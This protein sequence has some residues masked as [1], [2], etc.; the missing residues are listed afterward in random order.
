MDAT[1]LMDMVKQ[2]NSTEVLPEDVLSDSVYHF[3]SQEKVFE[4]AEKF[5]ARAAERESVKEDKFAE[6]G[7]VLKCLKEKKAAIKPEPKKE[8][9]VKNTV[10]NKGGEAI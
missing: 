10:K 4:L 3:D 5:A 1:V 2:V 7:S 9:I 6:K 8:D